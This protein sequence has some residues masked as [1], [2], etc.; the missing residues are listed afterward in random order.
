[1]FT[2]QD[3]TNNVKLSQ[4]LNMFSDGDEECLSLLNALWALVLG[5]M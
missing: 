2:L 5:E 4:R 1:M 3:P